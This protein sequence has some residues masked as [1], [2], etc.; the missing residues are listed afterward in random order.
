[1]CKQPRSTMDVF[2]QNKELQRHLH[3][4]TQTFTHVC[5]TSQNSELSYSKSKTKD[6]F[7]HQLHCSAQ[8]CI[9]M[10]LIPYAKLALN[11]SVH[12]CF[13]HSSR[14]SLSLRVRNFEFQ[15]EVVQN[16]DFAS[17]MHEAGK[18]IRSSGFRCRSDRNHA[19]NN[20][21]YGIIGFSGGQNGNAYIL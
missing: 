17:E 4:F 12:S 13:T 16:S 7:Q 9:H 3:R 6:G 8:N 21:K 14:S 15:Q 1:M 2:L 19:F 20:R 18:K 5:S 10:A 11:S